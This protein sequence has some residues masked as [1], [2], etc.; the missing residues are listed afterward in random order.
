MDAD[1][2]HTGPEG[3]AASA[4]ERLESWKEIA[5][6]LKRSVRTLHRWEK[7]EGLPIQRQL[8]KD[9][10]SVFAYKHEL[11][12]WAR[13]RSVRAELHGQI[14]QQASPKRFLMTIAVTLAVAAVVI[15][16][17]WYMAAR[18]AATPRSG[19]NAAVDRL[20]LISPFSGSHRWPTLSPDGRTI[21]FV[22]D[23]S[24]TPQVWIKQLGK[25]EPVQ[26]TFGDTPAARPRW[27]AQ[28]DRIVYSRAGSG[29]WSVPPIGG[30]ARQIIEKGWNADLSPD[31]ERLVFERGGQIFIAGA[32][33]SGA[34]E[35]PRPPQRLIAHYGDAWPTF[36]PDGKSIAVFLGE[37][38]RYGDYW[39]LPSEGGPPRRVTSDFQEGAAPAWTPD[40]KS[41]VIRSARAG[42]PNLWRVSVAGGTPEPLTTGAGEDFDP[43]VSPDGRTL[44]FANVKRTWTV[45]V[46][47]VRGGTRRMLLE[48]RTPIVYPRY[49][50]DGRRI[51]L[52]MMNSRGEMQLFVMDADGSNVTAV[53]DGVGDLNIMPQWSA[54]GETLYFYQVRP[55]QTFRRLSV[56][57]GA[58][59]AIA[60]WH[61]GR[62]YQ[63]AV[64]PRDRVVVYSAVENGRLQQSRARDLET[65]AETPLPFALYEQRFSRDGRL[66]AGESREHEVVLC[67]R[68]GRCQALTPKSDRMVTALAWSSDATRVFFLRHTTPR[69][70]AELTSV[71]VH[72]GAETVHG[73]VGPFERDFVISMDVSPRDE[74]V[75]AMHREGPHELWLANLR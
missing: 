6:Y 27:A 26:I 44:L 38:G 53:T 37:E 24:G 49:S 75:Y 12:A 52:Q 4:G 62:Q 15:G 30:E 20:E 71:G 74:I 48:R 18:R 45:V 22:S 9:L 63:A 60:P 65:D 51:A 40:G 54:D 21:A 28:G 10:G 67:T 64:D 16:S 57:S 70:W 1:S 47:D 61:F 56:S 31:G 72:G 23:A 13:A 29:I 39:L 3:D 33:G 35:L 73:R 50:P 42:S 5:T 7:E 66:I 34:H 32:D 17:V 58:S 55:T 46:Q 59:R 68:T 25:G 2:F 41:L 36:S 43:V 69:E 11:D 8:H 14:Q 19:P